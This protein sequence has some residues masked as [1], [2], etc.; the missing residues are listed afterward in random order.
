MPFF[1]Q[2]E[3]LHCDNNSKSTCARKRTRPQWQPPSRFSSIIRTPLD[4]IAAIFAY[5]VCFLRLETCP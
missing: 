3:Q 1:V 2:I 4:D 5:L